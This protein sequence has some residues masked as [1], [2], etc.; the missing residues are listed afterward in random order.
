MQAGRTACVF[1]AAAALAAAGCGADNGRYVTDERLN[2]G[3]IVILP[4]IEGHSALNRSIREGLVAAGVD[5][6]MPIHSWGRPIPIAGILL[7]QVD[8]LGNRLAGVD[9]ARMIVRYQDSHPGRPVHIIGHSGGG[10]IAVFA[11]EALPDG[12]KITGLVLLSASISAGYDLSDA[13]DHCE[14]GILS[15]YSHQDVGLLVIGTTLAG[16]V[17]GMRGAAAGAVG[18]RRPD[19]SDEPQKRLK[20]GKLYEV[21]LTRELTGGN[22]SAHTAATHAGFVRQYVAPWVVADA[23]PVTPAPLVAGREPAGDVNGLAP[24][25]G[26]GLSSSEAAD[27]APGAAAERAQKDAGPAGLAQR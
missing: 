15:F 11:A 14:N 3:L 25:A 10:G 6:A 26:R 5:Q 22:G 18:F 24:P 23:W 4:G 27:R 16:N 21:E 20:Y 13:L 9:I 8:I 17:D 2:R 12:R 19:D 1:L 7:N